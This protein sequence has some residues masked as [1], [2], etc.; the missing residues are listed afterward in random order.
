MPLLYVFYSLLGLIVGSFLN[1]CIYRI[2]RRESIVFPGS[3]CPHCGKGIRP[4]DNVPVFAYL[5]LRGKCRF[6]RKPISAQYPIVELLTGCAFLG[7]ALQWDFTSPTYVNTLFLSMVLVLVF[8]D[9]QHQ[10]LPNVITLPGLVLG[11]LLSPLQWLDFFSDRASFAISSLFPVDDP[12]TVLP[13]AG[14]LLGALLGGG[15]LFAVGFAYRIT[16][17]RQG[18]GMGDIKMMAMVG[19]FLG[20][21]FAFLTI[22]AGSLLGSVLGLFLVAFRGKT[23][24]TRLAFGTFLGAGAAL[25]LFLGTPFLEWFTRRPS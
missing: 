22:F 6:C 12:V 2:P 24:Q 10:I 1:V 11:L 20:W 4:Y 13:W 23:L 16:R 14:S 15:I 9:Y 19:A 5:W 17:G 21:R 18:M 7:C 8:I 3:H 25:A